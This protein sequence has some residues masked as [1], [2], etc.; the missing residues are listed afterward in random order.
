MID[1]DNVYVQATSDG[2]GSGSRAVGRTIGQIA[3]PVRLS[4]DERDKQSK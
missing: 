4:A 2:L 3:Y 1:S